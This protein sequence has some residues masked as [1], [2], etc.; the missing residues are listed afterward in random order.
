MADEEEMRG[1]VRARILELAPIAPAELT[2]ELSLTV[3]LGFDSL[4]LVQLAT[5]VED[6]LG[7]RAADEEDVIDLETVG[8]VEAYVLG[9]VRA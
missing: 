5:A 3:D 1:H 4:L 2:S 9:L 6:E 7:L 8:D